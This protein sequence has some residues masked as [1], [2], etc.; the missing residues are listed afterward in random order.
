MSVISKHHF[1]DE[2]AAFEY[3]E[4]TL[5]PNGPA[6]PHCGNAGAARI[7]RFNGEAHRIGVHKC[8]EC[9]KQFT[10]KVGTVFEHGRIP[11]HKMLQAAYLLC[12]SK[13]GCSSHQLHRILQ[14]TYKTAWFLSHRIRAA[15]DD[16]KLPP[17]G[18]MSEIVEA[19][20]T[21]F[22]AI[23][24]EGGKKAAR[25]RSPASWRLGTQKRRPD[26]CRARRFCAQLPYRDQSS[27]R[28]SMNWTVWAA[29][30]KAGLA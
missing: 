6:C 2:T 19:D 12:C 7:T 24:G 1:H 4:K 27:S 9:R 5:W 11:L 21:F 30:G 15:M 8:N 29:M 18:G 25:A 13:K 26:P 28:T 3:L 17:M 14:V 16:G 22:G 23:E 10:V 20:E